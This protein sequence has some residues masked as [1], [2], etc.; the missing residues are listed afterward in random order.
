MHLREILE[1][2]ARKFYSIGPL[3]RRRA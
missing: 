2:K 3:T 1:L